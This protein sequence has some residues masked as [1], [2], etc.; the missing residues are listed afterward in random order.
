MRKIWNIIRYLIVFVINLFILLFLHSYFNF[1]VLIILLVAPF[2][3]IGLAA[4]AAGSIELKLI[5]AESEIRVNEPFLLEVSLVNHSIVPLLEVTLSMECSNDFLG[6]EKT[7][8]LAIPAVP[9]RGNHVKYR[10]V[11]EYLGSFNVRVKD[12]RVQDWFGFVC[13]KKKA[14]LHRDYVILPGTRLSMEPNFFAMSQGMTETSES[15][16]GGHDFSEVF[17]VREYEPGDRLQNIHWKLSA[18]KDVFMVKERENMSSSELVVLVDLYQ[19]E[20]MIL[21]E[22]LMATYGI[23]S[24]LSENRIPFTFTYW[25]IKEQELKASYIQTVNELND[26]MRQVYFE[27]FYDTP[28][29]GKE[30]YD[31]L[32]DS[33]R[34]YMLV[35]SEPQTGGEV[36]F[37]TESGIQ[38]YLCS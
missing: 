11:S 27:K 16:T 30:M 31:R 38:G 36:V 29:L 17:D 7:H 5:S 6:T 18:K 28:L 24:Y 20:N 3:S 4:I 15:H 32:G 1:V 9:L 2:V 10:L 25:S 19:N 37:S 26:W 35:T 22:I 23:G 8:E 33:D 14:E 34:T 21:N 12:L 13:F